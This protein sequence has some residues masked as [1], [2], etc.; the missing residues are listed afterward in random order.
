M[1]PGALKHIISKVGEPRTRQI[2]AV[3]YSIA[4]VRPEGEAAVFEGWSGLKVF[5]NGDALPRVR[6]AR[7]VVMAKSWDEALEETFAAD[8][9]PRG[10][11]VTEGIRAGPGCDRAL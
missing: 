1:L 3:N 2:L 9:D 11:V 7:S 10:V 4:R 5:R 8:R 6:T